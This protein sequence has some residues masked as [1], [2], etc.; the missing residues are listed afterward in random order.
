[1]NS[2]FRVVPS[3]AEAVARGLSA[4]SMATPSDTER[5]GTVGVGRGSGPVT[6][7]GGR[8]GLD[9]LPVRGAV[10]GAPVG[11][12][13]VPVALG[14]PEGLWGVQSDGS[15]PAGAATAPSGLGSGWV[16]QLPDSAGG[17]EAVLSRRSR[18]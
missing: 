18:G 14:T 3:H 7:S 15:P 12:S 1:M 8:G 11:P 13:F 16:L 4:V 17:G 5:E 10:L 2:D 6:S 9:N